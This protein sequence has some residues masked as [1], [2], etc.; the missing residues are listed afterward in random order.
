MPALPWGRGP[1]PE[2]IREVAAK[3]EPESSGGW[4]G[5]RFR[6]WPDA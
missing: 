6:I 1:L 2:R 4:S 5:W 3:Q